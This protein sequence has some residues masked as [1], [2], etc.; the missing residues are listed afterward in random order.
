M[1]AMTVAILVVVAL[2]VLIFVRMPI[3]L[4]MG[5][6]GSLGYMQLSSPLG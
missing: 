1:S 2:F 6:V 4:A 5:V 3:A